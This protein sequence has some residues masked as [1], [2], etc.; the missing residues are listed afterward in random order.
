MVGWKF[1]LATL[2]S[3]S[4]VSGEDQSC[5]FVSWKN[6]TFASTV[7]L[8][9]LK[10]DYSLD[11]LSLKFLLRIKVVCLSLGE[12]LI[13]VSVIYFAWVKIDYI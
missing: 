2:L 12:I 6:L 13:F 8:V 5:L 11:G 9:K 1:Y 4:Q 3:K 7:Y 10:I